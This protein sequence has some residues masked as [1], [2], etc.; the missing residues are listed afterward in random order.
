MNKA[1]AAMVALA[2]TAALAAPAGAWGAT[3]TSASCVGTS[4]GNSDDGF[5]F[6]SSGPATCGGPFGQESGTVS[7]YG[8]YTFCGRFNGDLRIDTLHYHG[9]YVIYYTDGGGEGVLYPYTTDPRAV[10]IAGAGVIKL[11]VC[12]PP[13]FAWQANSVTVTG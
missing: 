13:G 8:T 6:S 10:E 12:S 2:A 4:A 1:G 9:Q 11:T 7:I 3:A 5:H